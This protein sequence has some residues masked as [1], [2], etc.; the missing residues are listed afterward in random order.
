VDALGSLRVFAAK[1]RSNDFVFLFLL[2]DHAPTEAALFAAKRWGAVIVVLVWL[3]VLLRRRSVPSVYSWTLGVTL[4][5]SPVVHPWYVTWL[6]PA[7]VLLPHVAWWTWS[8]LVIFAYVPLPL[9]KVSGIWEESL[10][11]K[12]L[13]YLPVLL[14]IPVQLWWERVWDRPRP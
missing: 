2:G 10:L 3:T 6:L 14:L 1:W 5:V 13:E 8:I 12:A 4:L 7:V 9:F 11:V